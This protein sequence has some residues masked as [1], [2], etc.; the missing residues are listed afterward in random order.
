[1]VQGDHLNYGKNKNYWQSGRPYLDGINVSVHSDQQTMVTQLESGALDLAMTPTLVDFNRLKSNPKFQAVQM[2]NPPN[3]YMI[4]PNSVFPPLDDKRV[5]QAF[6]YT[7]DRKRML[8]SVLLGI[9]EVKSLPW[10]PGTP[11]YEPAKNSVWNFDLDKAKS[12]LQQSGKAIPAFE[13]VFNAQSAEYRKMSEIWQ[14]DLA[15]IDVKLDIKGMEQG[16]LL[17]SWHNQTYKGFY[18]AS[19]AWTNM[20]P[21]TFF[22]SS[23]V[24]RTSGNNGGYSNPTYTQK[25][26]ALALEPDESKRKQMLSDL[27]DF[28]LDEAI[29]YPVATNAQT[30][31]ASTRVHGVGQRRIP[32]FK[33]TDAWLDA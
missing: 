18:I 10:P 6:A 20:Q 27:N 2:D 33:F 15:K 3:F 8:D 26:N 9:G 28:Q 23:S 12:L 30:Y 7:I 32:L 1:L 14:A 22:T 16:A 19:D 17:D 24:A 4:Q 29:V 13:M 25:V 31:V 11:A 5:R 21:I